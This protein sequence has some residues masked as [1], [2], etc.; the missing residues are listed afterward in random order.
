M[1]SAV[2]LRQEAGKLIVGHK[3][4]LRANTLKPEVVD[5]PA[6]GTK[7]KFIAYRLAASA[8][9]EVVMRPSR[10]VVPGVAEAVTPDE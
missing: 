3:F 2:F 4:N 9:E 1:P 6:A 8:S 5:N 7:H 10:E